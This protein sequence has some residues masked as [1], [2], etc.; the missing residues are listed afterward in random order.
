MTQATHD[1][2]K[3]RAALHT[4]ASQSTRETSLQAER[5]RRALEARRM[6]AELRRGKMKSFRPVVGSI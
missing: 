3:D 1:H 2:Q 6:G 5:A 4:P